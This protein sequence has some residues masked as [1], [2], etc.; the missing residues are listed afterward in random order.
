VRRGLITS[1][2][3]KIG[4]GKEKFVN[5]VEEEAEGRR[6]PRLYISTGVRGSKGRRGKNCSAE[7]SRVGRD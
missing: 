5:A 7:K 3:P 4:A 1:R 2:R 6:R